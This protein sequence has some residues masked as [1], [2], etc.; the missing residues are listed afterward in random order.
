METICVA[1]LGAGHVGS[2]VLRLLVDNE[3]S[4]AQRVGASIA[5]RRV[6]VRDL[7]RARR[8]PI[9]PAQLTTDAQEILNDPHVRVVIEVMG[10]LEPARTHVLA[11]MRAGKHVVT[12]NKALVATHGAE[13]F[14][15]AA[16]HRVGLA[17]E[18]SVAGGIPIMRTLREGLASD[19]VLCVTGIVNGTSNYILDA[20]ARHALSFEAAL[21]QAQEAGFAEADPTMDVDGHDAAQKLCLLALLA[22]GVRIDPSDVSTEG[23]RDIRAFDIA[24]AHELG[25]V[26]RHLAV[27]YRGE[28]GVFVRVHPAMVP[29][30]SVFAG[31]RSAYN[32]VL[33]HSEALGPSFYYGR[34]A[35][36]M[37][38]AVS[39]TSDLIEICRDVVAK[40][41]V[42]GSLARVAAAQPLALANE[43]HENY[44]ALSVRNAPG[45]LGQVAATL[46]RHGV[47]ISRAR[48]DGSGSGPV[49]LVLVTEPTPEAALQQALSELNALPVVIGHARRMRI[50]DPDPQE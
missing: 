34:G 49:D 2:G 46:G 21:A 33:V 25:Y 32:A 12:A 11:A 4:I 43:Q 1:L 24:A 9:D 39:V 41:P 47:S 31:V 29:A 22:F 20:M 42:A 45:V 16:E 27:A 8:T 13:L 5:V 10:G 36:M 3:A 37:P 44:V 48:Q 40:R 7:E 19:R 28:S 18:A 23:I 30:R 50:C 38:T 6:L 17:F 14:A 15:A 26:V 35:G